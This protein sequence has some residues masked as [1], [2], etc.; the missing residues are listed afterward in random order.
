MTRGVE[1]IN[2][3]FD[4]AVPEPLSVMVSLS[5]NVPSTS[6]RVRVPVEPSSTATSIIPVAPDVPPVNTSPTVKAVPS[7]S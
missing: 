3:P 2:N 6:V 1:S 5:W 7:A 4:V